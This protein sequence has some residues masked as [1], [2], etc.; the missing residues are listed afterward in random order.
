M[1]RVILAVLGLLLVSP[2]AQAADPLAEARRLYN[3]GRYE[4]AARAARES[5]AMDGQADAARVV[6]GRVEL[7]RF[8]QTADPENLTSAREA[9]R[10]VDPSLRYN[11]RL[12]LAISRAEVLCWTIGS[13]PPRLFE[14]RWIVGCARAGGARARAGLVGDSPRSPRAA[15]AD[16]GSA[17]HLRPHVDRMRAELALDAGSAPTGY[18]LAAAA[19]I[20]DIERAWQAAI[21]GWVR[22][23]LAQDRGA[24][25]RPRRLVTQAIIPERAARL[26]TGDPRQAAGGM[27]NEWSSFKAGWSR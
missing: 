8:R 5:M 12:E 11:G 3:A 22:A 16:R 4:A 15:A 6:L 7:E 26:H 2:A 25:R 10:D 1:R 14:A 27:Q 21:A 23:G 13:G 24:A 18:W 9:L 20:R 19:R 17:R